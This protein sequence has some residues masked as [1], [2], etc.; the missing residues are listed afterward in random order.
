[1]PF[2]E[3]SN[4]DMVAVISY[5]RTLPSVHH[6]V[7]PSEYNFMGK[8]VK[9]LVLKPSLPN[10]EP[11]QKIARDTTAAYGKYLAM[12]VANCHGCHTNRNMKTGEF[13]GKPFSGGLV[14][15]PTPE[16]L[17]YGFRTPNLTP[18]VSTGRIAEWPQETFLKRIHQGRLQKGSP[19]PWGPFSRMDE[20]DLKA[21]YNFL[22]NIEPVKNEIAKTVFAPG[23]K[24]PEP[25]D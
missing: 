9:T 21:L 8:I 19:M 17:D 15:S 22:H 16:S 14:F 12:S 18:D 11:P 6:K 4:E 7:P 20:S 2:Q 13:I 1:M 10:T 25:A 3:L 24:M 23:E 5:L